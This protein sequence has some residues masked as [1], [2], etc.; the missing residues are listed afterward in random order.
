MSWSPA[1]IADG[2]SRRR[3][4]HDALAHLTLVQRQLLQTERLTALGMEANAIG[5]EVGEP[6][7]DAVKVLGI[8]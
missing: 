4:H 2:D 5:L 7:A 8:F 1:I 3:R 6:I